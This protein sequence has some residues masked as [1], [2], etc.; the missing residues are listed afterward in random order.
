L[1][2]PFS[3][4]EILFSEDFMKSTDGV[5][6]QAQLIGYDGKKTATRKLGYIDALASCWNELFHMTLKTGNASSGFDFKVGGA[7]TNRRW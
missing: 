4:G 1:E 2:F 5:T 6:A 3:R 7:R